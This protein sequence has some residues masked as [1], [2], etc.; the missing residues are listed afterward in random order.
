MAT[1]TAAPSPIDDYEVLGP[2]WIG[3]PTEHH[4]FESKKFVL[5]FGWL[6]AQVK[7]V[8][9][10]AQVYRSKGYTAIVTVGTS[11]DWD[12]IWKYKTQFEEFD[13]LIAYLNEHGL[14]EAY[15]SNH[16]PSLFGQ[17]PK[18]VIHSFSNGGMSKIQRL[19][20]ALHA[21][22]QQL[23]RA[24]I[25]LDSS[26]GKATVV[27]WS[28]Y[29]AALVQNPILK[30]ITYGGAYL[31]GCLC[32]VVFDMKKHPISQGIPYI[33]SEKNE[34]GNI[35]GPRLFL[36]SEADD[37]IQFT[38][39]KD[40]IETTRAEGIVVEEKMFT[41]S[42]HVKHAVDFKEEYW[43]IKN[44][45]VPVT[46]T[47]TPIDEYEVLGPAWIG[48]PAEHH[49]FESKKFVL[50]FGWLD[51][52]VKY[53]E[54]YAQ[55]YRSKG[56]TAI[57]TVCTSH[58][59]GIVWNHKTQFEEFDSLI[60]YLNEHGLLE[61]YGSHHGPS[62]FGQHPKLVIHSFS[63]GGMSKIQRLVTA[64]HAKGQQLKRAHIILDSSPGR[65][66]VASWS[67]FMSASVQNPILKSIA[68]SCAYSVATLG[69]V[70]FD[71][72][73]YPISQGVPY[74]VSEKNENGNIRGP[75]LFLYS[76]ADNVVQFTDVKDHV[77][78]TRAEGIVVEEKMFTTSAHVKHAVDFKE[79]YLN[80]VDAFLGKHYS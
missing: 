43:N 13:S 75:R 49:L 74:I 15:G 45:T 42:A 73:K 40:H 6:D 23:K 52:Q 19:V 9:K 25:I 56:Y 78:T 10:Y 12:I 38:D 44:M 14:L 69:S 76:E 31:I 58:D 36:Y 22:G 64:L 1:A 18:L 50:L 32:A 24:H 34:N 46:A 16:G 70:V 2:A 35:R 71:F 4:L 77:E 5:L 48:K 80:V 59:W 72:K 39:V 62:L 47:P 28:G 60:A 29:V 21:K 33:V 68:Y 55:V 61:A 65:P 41:T 66:T 17:H 67:G 54:K 7:Y 37:V 8:E 27:S 11:H 53:V 79:E 51:A 20:T 3:K 57:V 30:S 63:N 26:P